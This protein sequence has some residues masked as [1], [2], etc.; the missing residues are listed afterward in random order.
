MT[1]LLQK[2]NAINRSRT[3]VRA[4]NGLRPTASGIAFTGRL[5]ACLL[6]AGFL[7]V[8]STMAQPHVLRMGDG[9]ISVDIGGTQGNQEVHHYLIDTDGDGDYSDETLSAAGT[10][11]TGQGGTE[12][13]TFLVGGIALVT[14]TTGNPST[15]MVT[16]VSAGGFKI[17]TSQDG[18]ADLTTGAEGTNNGTPYAFVV[19]SGNAP[20]LIGVADN[21]AV[22]ADMVT[23]S[24]TPRDETSK[25]YDLLKWFSDPNDIFLTF[26][27]S[28]DMVA[29]AVA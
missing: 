16:P 7:G 27:A 17:A 13:N 6:L 11:P 25:E 12:V 1:F 20:M 3:E 24:L 19:L 28:V 18:E 29:K 5:A 15:L 2:F 26:D 14:W 4:R 21:A 10:N 22:Q 8:G 23:L 9:A